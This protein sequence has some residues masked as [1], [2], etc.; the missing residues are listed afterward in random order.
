ML[1]VSDFSSGIL[2]P[3]KTKVFKGE[4]DY[5][6]VQRKNRRILQAQSNGTASGL[7]REMRIDLDKTP[8]L[9]WSWRIE[10]SLG[11]LNEQSKSGDDYAA[12]IYVISSGGLAFW[13]TKALNYVWSSN[14]PKESS[15][16]NA[17]AGNNAIMVAVRSR[18]DFKGTWYT[19]KRHIK[20]DLK[21]Y[22]D[23]NIRYI[24]VVA[25]M[26]DTDNSGKQASAYYGEIYFSAK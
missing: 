2:E 24:N 14:S 11:K 16:P 12:R 13:R 26:T 23:D 6:I 25:I 8:Y 10:T 9:N 20:S 21:K 3:W 4:T 19:E 18:Q 1:K 22:F 15:W 17:F 5:R 7:Y